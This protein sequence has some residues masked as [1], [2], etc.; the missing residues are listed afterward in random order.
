MMK[1]S[2]TLKR[3]KRTD[4]PVEHPVAP[5]Q[6]KLAA[7]RKKPG[8]EPEV[9]ALDADWRMAMRVAVNKPKPPE[10]FPGRPVK[11]RAAKKGTGKA[12]SPKK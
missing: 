5:S 7:S 1:K 9:V 10:G 11:K 8:P 6:S 3:A 4:L 2:K 12:K